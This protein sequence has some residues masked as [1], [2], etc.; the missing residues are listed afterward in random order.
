MRTGL[1][2]VSSLFAI[3]LALVVG[4]RLSSQALA[5]V[6]GAVCGVSATLPV[7]LALL[8]LASRE[9]RRSE[10]WEAPPTRGASAPP[11]IVYSPPQFNPA[12][13]ALG[14]AQPRYYMPPETAT[15]GMSRDFRI[16]GEEE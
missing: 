6:V 13:Y 14:P 8:I 11:V 5:V 12:P 15:P 16:I 7:S 3:T 1:L 4:Q 2:I 9:W 10:R